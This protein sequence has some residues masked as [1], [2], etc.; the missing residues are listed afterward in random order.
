MIAPTL[1]RHVKAR[2]RPPGWIE[3]ARTGKFINIV[4]ERDVLRAYLDRLSEI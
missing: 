2:W 3:I 4:L 1:S